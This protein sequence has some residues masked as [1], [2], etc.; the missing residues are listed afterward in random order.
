MRDAWPP[1]L[2]LPHRKPW[3]PE[4]DGCPAGMLGSQESKQKER[5]YEGG[6]GMAQPEPVTTATTGLPGAPSLPGLG[7]TEPARRLRGRSPQGIN[8]KVLCPWLPADDLWGSHSPRDAPER[9][10]GVS[11]FP[12]PQGAPAWALVLGQSGQEDTPLTESSPWP[13]SAKLETQPPLSLSPLRA[14]HSYTQTTTFKTVIH[15]GAFHSVCSLL[16]IL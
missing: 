16:K 5:G 2:V 14:Q 11:L 10:E 7:P 9:D 13:P 1:G 3:A 15:T 6:S 8:H 4:G 12:P